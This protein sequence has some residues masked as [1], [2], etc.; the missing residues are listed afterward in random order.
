MGEIITFYSYKGGVGRTM[1]LANVA[2]LMSQWGYNVLI[3]DWDLEAPGLEF[4]FQKHYSSNIGSVLKKEGVIDLLYKFLDRQLDVSEVPDLQDCLIEIKIPESKAPLHFLTAG[5][6]DGDYTSRVSGL[7]LEAFYEKNGGYFLETLRE[8]W[9]RTYDFVLIDSRTGI[10]DIGG[11]CTIQ[12]PDIFVLLFTATEQ[13]LQGTVN[14][15]KKTVVARQ[16]L[17][18]NRLSLLCLPVPSRFDDREEFE[19]SK[20]WLKRFEKEISSLYE[21]WLPTSVKVL[22][23]LTLTK[24]PYM[25]YFSFGEK[26]PVLE[27]GTVDTAGLGYAYETI[28]SLLGNKLDY[29]NQLLENREEYVRLSRTKTSVEKSLSQLPGK[30][31]EASDF[32]RPTLT[33]LVIQRLQR[34]ESINLYGEPGI[35]KTRLLE[36]I[37][38]AGL[39]GTHIILV[40]FRR[41]QYS[42]DGFCKAVWTEAGIEGEPVVSL[43]QI[44]QKLK[45]RNQPIFFFI[46]DFQYLPDNPDIDAKFNQDFIVCLNSIK[47]STSV[48]LLTVTHEPVNNL[49][50]FINKMP[51]TSVLN[52]TQL[53]VNPLKHEEIIRELERRFADYLLDAHKKKILASHLNEQSDNY[54]LLMNYE[55]KL[56]TQSDAHLTFN[57]RLDT[58]RIHFRKDILLKKSAT[59]WHRKIKSWFLVMAPFLET[60]GKI[61]KLT[62]G[63]GPFFKSIA[64]K[65]LKPNGK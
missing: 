34:G 28:A 37:R 20:K 38:K 53:E 56:I 30:R 48:S 13:S 2:T 32:L 14:I 6:R 49:V 19:L 65:F 10:T 57:Q 58:W 33:S 45:D 31:T 39:E 7:D 63:A 25:T 61:K 5:K 27:Q 17:P 59:Q 40:S 42:Y 35:G 55:V 29:V 21:D 44:I 16:N 64:D 60:I 4:F 3:V 36:D 11:I 62:A 1:A 23:M 9:K 12:L 26:L 43:N 47:N 22:D 15:V 46:D 50:I 52:L 24:I 8:H 51:L 54:A 18:V 41:Y